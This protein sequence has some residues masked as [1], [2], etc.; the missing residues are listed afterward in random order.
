MPVIG[1]TVSHYQTIEKLGGTPTIVAPDGSMLIAV[2]VD[3]SIWRI[4]R[5]P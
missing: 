5:V 1:Q 2:D 4:S 3:Q